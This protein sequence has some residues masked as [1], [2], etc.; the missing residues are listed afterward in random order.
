MKPYQA[1]KQADQEIDGDAIRKG[2]EAEILG[3]NKKHAPT[4]NNHGY[5]WSRYEVGG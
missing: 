2:I 5:D 4:N 3:Y 1:L